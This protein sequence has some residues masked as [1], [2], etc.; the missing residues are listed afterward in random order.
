MSDCKK[1]HVRNQSIS[2]WL[3]V[4]KATNIYGL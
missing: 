4:W 3:W 1:R 2:C